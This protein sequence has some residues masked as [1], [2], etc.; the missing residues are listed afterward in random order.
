MSFFHGF[1]NQLV[2]G[3]RLPGKASRDGPALWRVLA[4]NGKTVFGRLGR[5]QVKLVTLHLVVTE[6]ATD[7]SSEL[8]GEAKGERKKEESEKRT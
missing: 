5:N 8:S 2:V 4:V 1:T 6:I 7:G 3:P